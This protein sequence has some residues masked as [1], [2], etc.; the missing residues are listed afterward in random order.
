MPDDQTITELHAAYCQATGFDLPLRFDRQR[1]WHDFDKAGFTKEDLLLVI[2]WIRQ[3]F[4]KNSGYGPTSLRMSTLLFR[5]DDFE[6]KLMLARKELRPRQPA[7]VQ[8]TQT[9]GDVARTVEVP[10]PAD[11]PINAGAAAGNVLREWRLAQKQPL[12]TSEV[13]TAELGRS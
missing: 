2:K 12:P 5:L 4:G 6:E 7:F 13:Q 8:K 1:V 3:Q 10:A 9:V 11:D